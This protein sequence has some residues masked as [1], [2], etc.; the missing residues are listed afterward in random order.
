MADYV[1]GAGDSAHADHAPFAAL[2]VPPSAGIGRLRLGRGAP[3]RRVDDAVR[4]CADLETR[5]TF[6]AQTI[7]EPLSDLLQSAS[8][9]RIAGYFNRLTDDE[10]LYAV[11]L[12]TQDSGPMIASQSFPA[13]VK[14]ADMPSFADKRTHHCDIGMAFCT[15][16][17]AA[18]TARAAQRA[19]RARARHELHRAAQRGNP[20]LPLLL[21]RGAWVPASR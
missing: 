6:V 8:P 11:G 15:S 9:G 21:L 13:E 7:R 20:A 2:P 4:T 16:R 14:C 18:S 1:H 10:R 19:S 5:S 17:C 12:C 3:R